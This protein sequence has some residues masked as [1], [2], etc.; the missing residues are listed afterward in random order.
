MNT[1]E[2]KELITTI[3][4]K[5]GKSLNT[6]TDFDEFSLFLEKRN[7]GNVSSSTLKRLWGYVNDVRK[8]RVSTLNILANYIGESSYDSFVETL[9]RSHRY[10]SSFFTA[11]Q[12]SS[13]ELDTGT[14]LEIGWSPNRIVRLLYLGSSIYE[15]ILSKNSKLMTGDRFMTGCFFK[16][17]PL[18]LPYVERNGEKTPP[19]IAGRNGGLSFINIIKNEF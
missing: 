19:F 3:E 7:F 4:S 17:L 12:L 10:N 15:V 2:I 1:P 14:I 13:S 6:T 5:Y 16:E 9:K 8:P 11:H 18:Y